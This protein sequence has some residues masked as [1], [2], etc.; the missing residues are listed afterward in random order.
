MDARYAR[1]LSRRGQ[2]VMLST[3]LAVVALPG[4]TLVAEDRVADESRLFPF[5]I[6]GLDASRSATD[7]SFL[8]TRPIGEKQAVEVRSN[9]V[10]VEMSGS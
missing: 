2:R 10:F 4:A 3:M 5:L 7:M 6:P 8:N 1:V 9:A